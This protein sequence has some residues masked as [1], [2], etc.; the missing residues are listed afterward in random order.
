MRKKNYSNLYVDK[1]YDIY[2]YTFALRSRKCKLNRTKFT[3]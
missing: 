2:I 3:S 1:I